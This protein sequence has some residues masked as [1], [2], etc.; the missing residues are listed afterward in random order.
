MKML[1]NIPIPGFIADPEWGNHWNVGNNQEVSGYLDDAGN[2]CL[3]K[4]ARF[5]LHTV[6]NA[7]ASDLRKLPKGRGV[8]VPQRASYTVALNADSRDKVRAQLA[9]HE[10]NAAGERI[11]RVTVGNLD[12]VLF[13]PNARTVSLVISL[14]LTG[15]GTVKLRGLE[16]NSASAAKLA[17]GVHRHGSYLEPRRSQKIVERDEFAWI[18]SVRKALYDGTPL[19]VLF[20]RAEAKV[21]AN[22][23]I[24]SGHML[25][26]MEVVRQLGLYEGLTTSQ[27]RRLFWHGRR[28]GF[29]THALHALDEVILRTRDKKDVEARANLYADYEFH[30]D[31]WGLLQGLPETD[32]Y[33][34][35][36][37]VLHMVGKALPERQTGYTV[38][39]KYTTETLLSAGVRCVI[40]VQSGGN[41][42][43]GLT[44]TIEHTKTGIPTVLFAG[45]AK[46]EVRREVWM[47]NNAQ[48]LY[49]LVKRVKPSVIHAHSDFVNGALATHV[50]EA[51]RIP[52][53]Y[54]ARGFWEETWLSRI[55]QVQNWED[56][57]LTVQMFGLPDLYN[58]RRQSERRVRERAHRVITLADTMKDF[59]LEESSDGVIAPEHISLARNAVDPDFF[60]VSVVPSKAREGLEIPEE[61]LVVGYISSIVEYEGIEVLLDAFKFLVAS[62]PAAYLLVVGDGPH[63]SRLRKKVEREG[64][65]N[66]VL[67]GRV[68]HEDILSYYHA[69][70]I[71]VVPRRRSRVTE[72]VTPLKPFEAFSTGR[73]VVLSDV[74]ALAEI[75]ADAGEAARVFRADDSLDLARVLS[76][77]AEHPEHRKL[78]GE[79]AAA[80]VREKRSWA[81]NVP[82]Y[83]RVYRELQRNE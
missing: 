40:A 22:L 16:F 27:L 42:D 63:L 76:E 7:T 9:I 15:Q 35:G 81:R 30:R 61:S 79:H 73:A 82:V 8:S 77:L 11:S 70:D 69:I 50:G 67:P 13:V 56:V 4:V 21:A 68:P 49:A 65:P 17:P 64:I 5:T 29:V 6:L 3:T 39:T 32:S 48:E 62:K 55:A 33:D 14:R 47:R 36:G 51:T 72:L 71:F 74:A 38:R 31:P 41:H 45:P 53:V 28:T 75:A 54:E 20:K 59:I 1:E 10:F 12:R 66:V 83:K 24:K 37:P 19:Q 44:E 26:A 60:P 80:W 23:F 52:V 57:D 43:E 25:E 46:Q 2:L 58:L 18:Q 34:S 78:M